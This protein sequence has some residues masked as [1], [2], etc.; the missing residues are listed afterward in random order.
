MY[1]SQTLKDW[2]ANCLNLGVKADDTFKGGV[3]KR[4]SFVE[5]RLMGFLLNTLSQ[6]FMAS[7]PIDL[8]LDE[9]I[10]FQCYIQRW[11]WR[12]QLPFRWTLLS[13]ISL[14]NASPLTCDSIRQCNNLTPVSKFCLEV[15]RKFNLN[16]KCLHWKAI[17]YCVNEASFLPRLHDALWKSIEHFSCPLY[18]EKMFTHCSLDALRDTKGWFTR[19]TQAQAWA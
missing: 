6:I 9:G 2:E 12:K 16:S 5:E 15:V 13:T 10:P 18:M 1:I 8:P 19:T 7:R 14:E 17:H 11:R 3:M 4:R